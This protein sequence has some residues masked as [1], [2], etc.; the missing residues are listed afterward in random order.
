[1]F[2]CLATGGARSS[3]AVVAAAAASIAVGVLLV[4]AGAA[5]W[6]GLEGGGAGR[7]W[8]LLEALAGGRAVT[9]ACWRL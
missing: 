4:W 2:W 7:C 8:V 6:M 9:L 5:V 3:S 1:M